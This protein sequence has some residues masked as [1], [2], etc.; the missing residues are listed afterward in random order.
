M[1][2]GR[3]VAAGFWRAGGG[4]VGKPA[5]RGAGY[6]FRYIA[7]R[8]MY[9]AGRVSP[10]RCP[11]PQRRAATSSHLHTG[12]QRPRSSPTVMHGSQADLLFAGP[13]TL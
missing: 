9:R 1:G 2:G 12:Y 4:W 8:G 6:R 11:S 7:L 5:Y 10:P 13:W 3:G